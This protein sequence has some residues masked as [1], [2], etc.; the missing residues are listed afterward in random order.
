[1][2]DGT[3]PALALG[4]ISEYKVAYRLWKECLRR[5]KEVGRLIARRFSESCCVLRSHSVDWLEPETLSGRARS[6]A[7]IWT[8]GLGCIFGCEKIILN[9]V[10]LSASELV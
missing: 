3:P 1:M 9:A 5:S 7:K 2:T 8:N 4:L 6:C 10:E